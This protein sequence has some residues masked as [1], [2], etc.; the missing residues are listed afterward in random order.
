MRLSRELGEMFGLHGL[1]LEDV[2]HAHQRA[3]VEDYEDHLFV[4]GRMVSTNGELESEQIALFLGSDFVLTFQEGL[5]GDCLDPLRERIRRDH[6]NVRKAGADYLAYAIIDAVVDSYFPVVEQYGDRLDELDGK[7]SS[8]PGSDAIGQVHQLRSELLMLRRSIWPH[9]DAIAELLRDTHE[10]VTPETRVYLRDTL[11]HTLQI[12]DV[13]HTYREMCSDLRD[14]FFSVVSTRTNEVMK[15]LT[16]IATIF[17]PLSFIAGVYGMNFD[18]MPELHWR[19]GYPFA[20]SVMS[21]V[22]AGL[23]GFMWRKGWLRD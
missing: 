17:I 10:L 2:V 18:H 5:P 20:L 6:G 21:V 3:K 8:K 4:V 19:M 13:I 15:V 1:A 22:A 14:F 16:I 23:I 7:L 11:D 9:Q 12:I